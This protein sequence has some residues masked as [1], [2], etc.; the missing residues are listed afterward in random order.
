MQ[1]PP[2]VQVARPGARNR[3]TGRGA[4]R[5]REPVRG[6][7]HRGAGR[8]PDPARPD[9]G[10]RPR[11]ASCASAHCSSLRPGRRSRATTSSRAR[12]RRREPV[13]RPVRDRAL[14]RRGRRCGAGL[15]LGKKSG[16]DSI[17]LKVAILGLDVPEERYGELLAAVKKLGRR[18]GVSSP[19]P[20]CAGLP[21]VDWT[22]QLSGILGRRD[23]AICVVG[24]GVIGSPSRLIRA[25]WRTLLS[26]TRR[27]AARA[28]SPPTAC[29][30]SAAEFTSARA[31]MTRPS[32]RDRRRDRRDQGDRARRCARALEGRSPGR[33]WSPSRTGS[34]RSRSCAATATGRSCPGSPS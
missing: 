19:T 15:V 31:P 25:E 17:R 33:S 34:A 3:A 5:Q 29:S 1:Q 12:A 4:G 11:R 27:W 8:H 30:S 16:L 21:E 26:A 7:C 14:R 22:C 6:R 28:P 18:S 13:P 2:A 10:A 32:S 23:R 20:S 24:A 9:P